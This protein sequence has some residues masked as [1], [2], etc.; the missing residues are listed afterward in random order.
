MCFSVPLSALTRHLM[1]VRGLFKSYWQ[2]KDNMGWGFLY[3]ADSMSYDVE[4]KSVL[5]PFLTVFSIPEDIHIVSVFHMKSDR[6]ICAEN[7]TRE[8]K[9]KADVLTPFSP[10]DTTALFLFDH[11][12]STSDEYTNPLKITFSH[13]VHIQSKFLVIYLFFRPYLFLSFPYCISFSV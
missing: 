4:I 3:L 9:S 7:K 11:P 10:P 1:Y 5:Y 6:T 12:T 2:C 13:L 8:L